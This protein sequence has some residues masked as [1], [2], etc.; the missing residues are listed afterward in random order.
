MKIVITGSRGFVGGSVGRFA[1]RQ[2]RDSTPGHIVND[3]VHISRDAR[4][5]EQARGSIEGVGS[6]RV[7]NQSGRAGRWAGP[8]DSGDR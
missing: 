4:L 8:C 6:R 5:E 7:Q 1:A 3:Q 2:G